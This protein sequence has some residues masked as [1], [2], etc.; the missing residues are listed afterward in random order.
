MTSEAI[1]AGRAGATGA[2]LDRTAL[3]VNQASII[4]L[5]AVGFVLDQPWLVAFVCV[6]MAIGTAFPRA[7]LFQRV[8]RD[9]LRPAGLLRPDVHVEDA[10]PHR[11][12][13]GLGAAVLLAA[14]AALFAGAAALGWGLAF[15]VIALAAINLIFGFCAGC[16]VY[17][18]LHRLRSR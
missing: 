6:V 9:L 5:L 7:A 17:F 4:V 2:P 1:S 15:V 11:F 3:R 18:Q 8:Y 13:Q 10:A 14:S 16:F 12:A